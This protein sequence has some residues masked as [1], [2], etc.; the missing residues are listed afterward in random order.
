MDLNGVLKKKVIK[1]GNNYWMDDNAEH[2]RNCWF[3]CLN[4]CVGPYF[5]VKRVLDE[6]SCV[7]HP[8]EFDICVDMTL[9]GN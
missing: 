3:Y 5:D 9:Y 2:W 7:Q 8:N 4:R 6:F 1:K